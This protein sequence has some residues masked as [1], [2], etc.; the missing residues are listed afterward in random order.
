[1]SLNTQNFSKMQPNLRERIM[2]E[3]LFAIPYICTIHILL[4]NIFIFVPL[5][6]SPTTIF[7]QARALHHTTFAQPNKYIGP[8]SFFSCPILQHS[9]SFTRPPCHVAFCPHIWQKKLLGD[10]LHYRS[11]P[12][13]FPLFPALYKTWEWH[14]GS[15][16]LPRS[17][18]CNWSY[19]ILFCFWGSQN[20]HDLES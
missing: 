3:N 2:A 7:R 11:V 20:F 8:V 9:V 10:G 4:K 18:D 12:R 14:A 17:H 19:V 6:C 13:S 16:F 5:D 1:M 15:T